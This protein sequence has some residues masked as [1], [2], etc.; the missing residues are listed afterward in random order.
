VN[1]AYVIATSTRIPIHFKIPPIFDDKYFKRAKTDKKK[2][3]PTT[4]NPDDAFAAKPSKKRSYPKDKKEAQRKLDD[5]MVPLIQKKKLLARYLR[6][7]FS[8]SK[9]EYPHLLKF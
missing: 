6:S 4:T 7:R 1:Q 5:L 8:L 9:A 2:K 3:K